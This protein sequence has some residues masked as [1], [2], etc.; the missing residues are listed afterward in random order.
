[1]H[2]CWLLAPCLLAARGAMPKAR[3]SG[4]G[5][6]GGRKEGSFR[7]FGRQ[8]KKDAWER[9]HAWL[10]GN[11]LQKKADGEGQ[12]SIHPLAEKRNSDMLLPQSSPQAANTAPSPACEQGRSL[13]LP[14]TSP[15]PPLPPQKK[16]S[17][18]KVAAAGHH[19]IYALPPEIPNQMAISLSYEPQKSMRTGWR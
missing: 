2:C 11:A 8:A 19:P 10:P 15:T 4:G 13:P 17:K 18:A 16:P 5:T 14:Q 3:S 9:M 6:I 1:M 12:Q 7:G